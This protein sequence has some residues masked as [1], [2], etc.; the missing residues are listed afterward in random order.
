MLSAGVLNPD[1]HQQQLVGQLAELLQHLKEYSGQVVH[2][3]T[4]RAAYEV[5][6]HV[7]GRVPW[8]AKTVCVFGGGDQGDSTGSSWRDN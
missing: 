1:Q 6:C 7:S 3:K 5:G 2:Y 8:R 4:A